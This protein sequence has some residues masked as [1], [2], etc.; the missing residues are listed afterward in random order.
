MKRKLTLVS[1]GI[2]NIKSVQNYLEF[3][4]FKVTLSENFKKLFD[5]PLNP[6]FIAGV[7]SLDNKESLEEIKISLQKYVRAGVPIIGVCAG[8]QIF[9]KKISEGQ[10]NRGM[11]IFNKNVIPVNKNQKSSIGMYPI[12]FRDQSKKQ[13]CFFCHTYGIDY[14]INNKQDLAYYKLTNGKQI[15]AIKQSQNILGFQFHPEK[16]PFFNS[17]IITKFYDAH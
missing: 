7:A 5:A 16:S 9:F 10:G 6:I 14:D 11:G 4:D 12:I 1:T 3:L 17:N 15:L 8:F 2:G 13:L